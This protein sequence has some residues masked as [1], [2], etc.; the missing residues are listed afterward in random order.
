MLII[1]M[2]LPVQTMSVPNNI[3]GP[4][5]VVEDKNGHRCLAFLDVDYSM[6]PVTKVC[7]GVRPASLGA[8]TFF[9]STGYQNECRESSCRRESLHA[10]KI[11][12]SKD[13][14]SVFC[15]GEYTGNEYVLTYRLDD[16]DI[17]DIDNI[18][19]TIDEHGLCVVGKKDI[20][21]RDDVGYV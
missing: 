10:Y 7:I 14:I 11:V 5:C 20:V 18:Q 17:R 2:S 15:V 12:R 1:D 9:V 8:Y 4:V 13:T 3:C 16:I 6:C 21:E 19:K